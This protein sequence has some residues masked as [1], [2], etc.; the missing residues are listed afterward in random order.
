MSDQSTRFLESLS[1]GNLSVLPLEKLMATYPEL[2]S[3]QENRS[4]TSFVFTLTPFL[5]SE[6]LGYAKDESMV[7]YIDA[8]TLFFGPPEDVFVD[9]TANVYRSPHNCS[10]HL[11]HLSQYGRYNTG[12]VS[13]RANEHGRRCAA[14]W[15]QKCLEWCHDRVEDGK[16][17][18]QAYIEGFD[19]IVPAVRLIDN[20]GV[21]CA[22]WNASGKRFQR[23]GGSV[24]VNDVRLINFHFA[25]FHRVNCWVSAHRLG[26]QK[27]VGAKGLIEHVY[28]PY[29]K[30]LGRAV[31]EYRIPAHLIIPQ[32]P[33]R[34]ELHQSHFESDSKRSARRCIKRWWRGEYL[35]APIKR[36][37]QP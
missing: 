2:S 6:V 13:F 5:V 20:N 37:S 16:F 33:L 4:K 29:A 36:H 12:W 9:S 11:K 34:P 17:A 35:I 30:A 1:L 28:K 27:V 32:E 23:Y 26:A 24:W 7:T 18:D 10:E 25:M 8:D 3:A 22:P 19:Q 31:D 14:W 15:S 21:N